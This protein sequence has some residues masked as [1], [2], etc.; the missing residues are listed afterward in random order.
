MRHRDEIACGRRQGVGQRGHRDAH[1][2]FGRHVGQRDQAHAVAGVALHHR[3]HQR[4][5][6]AAFHQ[7]EDRLDLHRLLRDARLHAGILEHLHGQHMHGGHQRARVRDEGLAL[8]LGDGDLAALREGRIGAHGQHQVVQLQHREFRGRRRQH[9]VAH[10]R[11]V[12]R[13]VFDAPQQIG[14]GRLL[15]LQVHARVLAVKAAHDLRHQRIG[16]RA[17]E[18]DAQQALF[19]RHAVAGRAADLV[20]EEQR[21]LG[22]LQHG[23]A[24]GRE[25]QA[26]GEPVE[27]EHAEFF[28]E[29]LDRGGQRRLRHVQPLCGAVKVERLRQ[30]DDLPQLAKLH[31]GECLG[32]C[33]SNG[34]PA[35]AAKRC[36]S[37]ADYGACTRPTEAGKTR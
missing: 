13:V 4:H 26:G 15:D 20:D 16:G 14:G 24:G 18:A 21:A 11:E 5:A 27:Q 10:Q 34:W 8:Q 1:G 31:G 22:V 9:R 28:L 7:A 6:Q 33:G 37:H 17:D 35:A 3:R 30:D 36:R 29:L 19:A 12:E 32:D 25:P 23:F 2:V